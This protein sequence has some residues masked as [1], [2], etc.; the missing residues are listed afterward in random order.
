MRTIE[1]VMD[2]RKR[3]EEYLGKAEQHEFPRLFIIDK[4]MS[5]TIEKIAQVG[6][7]K[8]PESE[9]ESMFRV[10]EQLIGGVKK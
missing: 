6:I 10:V 7:E 9:L 1:E 5:V 4:G 2:L 8:Y 3:F